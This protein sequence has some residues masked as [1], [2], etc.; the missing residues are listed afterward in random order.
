MNAITAPDGFSLGM[1]A[2]SSGTVEPPRRRKPHLDYET[3]GVPD[4]QTT[5]VY[6]YAEHPHTSALVLAWAI[7]DEPFESWNILYGHAM[8][9]RL[10]EALLDPNV[11]LCAHNAS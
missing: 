5:G 2:L 4:L 7:D 10:R 6:A 3:R 8:P 9:A 1:T 11:I